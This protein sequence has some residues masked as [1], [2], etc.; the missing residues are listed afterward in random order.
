ML[1]TRLPET[2]P[3]ILPAILPNDSS[4]SGDELFIYPVDADNINF[5]IG[6]TLTIRVHEKANPSNI[7]TGTFEFIEGVDGAEGIG[8]LLVGDHF[9]VTLQ[10]NYWLSVFRIYQ[11]MNQLS[12]GGDVPFINI[13]LS[14][15]TEEGI[16]VIMSV[17]E[18]YIRGEYVFDQCSWSSAAIARATFKWYPDGDVEFS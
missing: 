14:L 1:P 7:M 18:Q 13:T 4:L 5:A 16:N 11:V 2:L 8:D 12:P 15:P 17:G 10:E 9:A 3:A 6:D